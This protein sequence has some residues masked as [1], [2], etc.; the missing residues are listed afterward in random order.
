M[1]DEQRIRAMVRRIVLRA[2]G[3]SPAETGARG[4]ALVTGQEVEA[5]RPGGELAIPVG[6]LITP[7]A[8]QVA[9][10]RKVSLVERGSSTTAA[11]R[12]PVG[13]AAARDRTVAVGGD[14]GGFELKNTVKRHLGTLGYTV[15]DVGSHTSAAV[16]YPDIAEA[17]ARK[18]AGGQAWRGIVVDGAGVG[19][20]MAA[21][22]IRGVR[23]A[24]CY[25]RATAINSRSHNDA[26][27]LTLG[28][29]ITDE[30]TALDIV[31]VWLDTPAE[32]GRHARRVAKIMD[33]ER[34]SSGG[35]NTTNDAGPARE[36]MRDAV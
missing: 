6:A 3:R 10:E 26:N 19:S 33:L 1:A 17:V 23:A 16:D 29:G 34:R 13:A 7:L 2:V 24:A 32:G 20:C 21:N 11:D 35:T 5:A 9:M 25:D 30:G 8:R 22:K 14:H 12:P 18:V 28:S 15:S 27:V 36:A 31:R 4:R